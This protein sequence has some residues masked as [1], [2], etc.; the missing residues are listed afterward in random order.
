MTL[1]MMALLPLPITMMILFCAA[2]IQWWVLCKGKLDLYI[3]MII[4]FSTTH[5]VPAD[6]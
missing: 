5:E 1:V 4:L 2:A 3:N 6:I